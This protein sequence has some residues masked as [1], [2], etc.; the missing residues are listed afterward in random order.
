MPRT[1]GSYIGIDANPTSSQANGI[2][3]VRDA[4]RLLRSDKWPSQPGVPGAP[5][6]YAGDGQVSLSWAAL[7]TSPAITDYGIQYSSNSGAAWTTFS[8]G[9]G[10]ATSATVTGLTN[11]TSY[12][13]RLYG[14]NALGD[15]PFGSASGAATPVPLD[16]VLLLHF[17][18]SNGST[19]FTDSSTYGRSV[20]SNGGAAISTAQ[21]KFGGASGLFDGSNDYVSLASG[22]WDGW[23][24]DDWTIE[25]WIRPVSL[26]TYAPVV[27][28][29][30]AL[31]L[32]LLNNGDLHLN[33]G[34]DGEGGLATSGALVTG[35]WQHVA[36]VRL[37]GGSTLYVDGVSLG[38][39]S[40]PYGSG[41][42]TPLEIGGSG[43]QEVYFNGY[44]DELRIARGTAVYV[45]N[46]TPPTA[47]F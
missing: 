13:F 37:S 8:D 41:S 30:G 22:P 43:S 38:S 40:V 36:A 39:T 28:A 18:G 46:F 21:S 23:D 7:T 17:N 5:S 26:G 2:W 32:H 15:G 4:E 16:T 35:Q 42:G 3:S 44:I 12:I 25:F 29:T 19:T 6:V 33:N 31:N 14:I 1:N 9:V 27:S 47:P 10:T 24:D 34:I 45:G 20:T 11:G